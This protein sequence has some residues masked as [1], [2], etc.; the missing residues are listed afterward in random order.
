MTKHGQATRKG[1]TRL[2][3]IWANMKTRTTNRNRIGWKDY[4]GR[5]ITVCDEWKDDFKAFYDWAMANGYRDDLTIDRINNDGNYEPGNC[6]W[7]TRREQNENKRA[8]RSLPVVCVETN[9]AY[10]NARFAALAVGTGRTNIVENLA[11]R[12]KTAG[13]YHWRYLK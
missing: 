7:A 3:R 5:G 13:G 6:R 12:S 1:Q 9:L 4:G 11:G 8:D 10:K 2:Y